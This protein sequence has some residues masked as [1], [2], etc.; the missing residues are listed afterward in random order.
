M[1]VLRKF[2]FILAT[3]T[4]IFCYTIPVFLI[5]VNLPF[6]PYISNSII[7]MRMWVFNLFKNNGQ[8]IVY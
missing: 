4:R 8:D 1:P 3:I 2:W 7:N 5:Y 6:S